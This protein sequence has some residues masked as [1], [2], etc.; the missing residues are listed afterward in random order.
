[1]IIIL[2]NVGKG[3]NLAQYLLLYIAY[4]RF[5]RKSASRFFAIVLHSNNLRLSLNSAFSVN[6]CNFAENRAARNRFLSLLL[7]AAEPIFPDLLPFCA[8]ERFSFPLS[9][10]TTENSPSLFRPFRG[11]RFPVR[12]LNPTSTG[13]KIDMKIDL[14]LRHEDFLPKHGRGRT[15]IVI[16]VLRA[17]TSIVTA[18]MNGVSSII[19]VITPAEAFRMREKHGYIMK[20]S[21]IAYQPNPE[22]LTPQKHAIL[23][24]NFRLESIVSFPFSNLGHFVSDG[25]RKC[26]TKSYFWHRKRKA[27]ASL[28]SM[29]S[30]IYSVGLGYFKPE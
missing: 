11:K 13:M 4:T 15:A 17:S 26:V 3:G 2:A 16:D 30:L 14:I 8:R 23:Q 7:G 22:G 25:F 5:C 12:V 1:M 21:P 6:F 27:L 18:I 9:P 19:P 29:K 10:S 20:Y 28:S 24:G